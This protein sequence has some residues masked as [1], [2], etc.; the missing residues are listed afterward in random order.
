MTRVIATDMSQVIHDSAIIKKNTMKIVE[1]LAKQDRILEQIAWDRAALS[2]G[3]ATNQRTLTMI[4][5]CFESLTEYAGSI[6]EDSV[7]EDAA[8]E[9][10]VRSGDGSESKA[11]ISNN[12]KPSPVVL[13]DIMT[14]VIGNTHRLVIPAAGSSNNHLW[15]FY[16]RTSWPEIIKEVRV[17]L[18]SCFTDNYDLQIVV[19]VLI[20]RF[21]TQH[22]TFTP[23]KYISFRSPPYK[24]TCT[25]WGYFTIGVEVILKRGYIWSEL[26]GSLLELEW[27][28]DFRSMGSST[29]HEY[30]VRRDS[31]EGWI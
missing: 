13:D 21:R 3:S 17:Y 28:L 10:R 9:M 14:L 29:S 22:E 12:F 8:E 7:S 15:S 1:H 24:I 19:E 16:L 4:D 2:R 20:N 18:V 30:A 11:L 31:G 27:D 23:P 5:E 25:G 26:D 6:C